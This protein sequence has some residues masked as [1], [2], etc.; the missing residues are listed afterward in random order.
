M[1]NKR[2]ITHAEAVLQFTVYGEVWYELDDV[3]GNDA[4]T[5]SESNG[6]TI[7]DVTDDRR[8]FIIDTVKFMPFEYD[9]KSYI[10]RVVIDG[11]IHYTVAEEALWD[12]LNEKCEN[13]DSEAIEVDSRIVYYGNDEE[14]RL[15]DD[16]LLETIYAVGHPKSA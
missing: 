4:T 13:W 3:D 9:G 12:V 11:E 16:E 10:S 6:D 15:S 5:V 14:M 1:N 8:Y 7:E 2:M